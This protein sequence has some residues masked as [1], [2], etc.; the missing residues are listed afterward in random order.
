MLGQVTKKISLETAAV[1][2]STDLLGITQVSE[3]WLVPGC[4]KSEPWLVP[5]CLNPGEMCFLC[6]S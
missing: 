3:P 4:V 6:L 5:G 1:E 2:T